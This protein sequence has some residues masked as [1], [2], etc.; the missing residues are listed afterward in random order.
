MDDPTPQAST[1]KGKEKE[2][3]VA[4]ERVLELRDFDDSD[5]EADDA[6]ASHLPKPTDDDSS[7]LYHEIV[8]P[9]ACYTTF[10]AVLSYITTGYVDF[11]PLSATRS[12]E[13]RSASR[14][15]HLADN[16]LLPLRASPKSV[17]RLAHLLELPDLAALALANIERQLTVESVA[18]VLFCDVSLCY[19]AVKDVAL[20]YALRK[21]SEVQMSKGMQEVQR[22]VEADEAPEYGKLAFELLMKVGKQQKEQS[23][24]GPAQHST[25][26]RS[27]VGLSDS[28]SDEE[29]DA[30]TTA[31]DQ[32]QGRRGYAR[33]SR[34]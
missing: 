25:Q 9:Q 34:V 8:L 3:S 17:Y 4:P 24:Q 27:C 28:S 20:G 23:A 21:W 26:E 31:A 12:A 7:A 5:D 18:Q 6:T 14:D 15:K 32:A 13:K 11:A 30:A 2:T 19:D 1:S 10:E 22:Q 16:P 29:L 33:R